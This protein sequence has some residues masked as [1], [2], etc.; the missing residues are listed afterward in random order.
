M[1]AD[2][3][4]AA[5]DAAGTRHPA[6]RSRSSPCRASNR[7]VQIRGRRDADA[8]REVGVHVSRTGS[9][10]RTAPAVRRLGGGE[11][12]EESAAIIVVEAILI[13]I[14]VVVVVFFV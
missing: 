10:S 5:A 7:C 13:A 9:P 14:V 1:A 3:A 4:P 12:R 6:G 11:V 2:A 8:I